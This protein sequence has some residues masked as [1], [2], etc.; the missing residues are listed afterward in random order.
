M[1]IVGDKMFTKKIGYRNFV[2]KYGYQYFCFQLQYKCATGC[3]FE[4]R[5]VDLNPYNFHFA[6]G[7]LEDEVGER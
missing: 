6:Q 5:N 4:I 2:K 7:G 1:Y 3:K